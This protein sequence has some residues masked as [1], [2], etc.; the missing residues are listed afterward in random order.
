MNAHE[1]EENSRKAHLGEAVCLPLRQL[2][3]VQHRAPVHVVW[4]LAADRLAGFCLLLLLK[5]SL[6]YVLEKRD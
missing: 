1:T 6:Q 3:R 5:E 4:V 2:Q